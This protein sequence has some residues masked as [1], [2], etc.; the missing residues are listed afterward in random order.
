MKL[1]LLVLDRLSLNSVMPKTGT[2]I[3]MITSESVSEKLKVSTADI[4]KSGLKSDDKGMTVKDNFSIEIGFNETEIAFIKDALIK[5]D[6]SGKFPSYLLAVHTQL[7]KVE[8]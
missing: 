7:N 8:A 1:N 2:I 5:L 6:K 3:E 4:E